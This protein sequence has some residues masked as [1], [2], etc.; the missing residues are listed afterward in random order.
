MN[1]SIFI[2]NNNYTDYLCG[3][4]VFSGLS[5]LDYWWLSILVFSY[6]GIASN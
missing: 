4:R 3:H 1:F 5:I 6:G 2:H